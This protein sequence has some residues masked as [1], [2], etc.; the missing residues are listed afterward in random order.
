MRIFE[1]YAR[2]EPVRE[3]AGR[4][5]RNAIPSPSGSAWN[6]TVFIAGGGSGRGIIGNRIYVGELVWK[7]NRHAAHARWRAGLR[8]LRR[9]D[10]DRLVAGGE[11]A[12][13]G[14]GNA[15]DKG[16]CSNSKSYDLTEIEATVLGAIRRNL[17]VEALTAFTEGARQEWAARQKAASAERETVHR[18]LNRTVEKRSPCHRDCRQRCRDQA[19]LW[20]N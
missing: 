13:V 3:I 16:I 20:R 9:A 5:N 15:R 6:H 14:C 19:R 7:E 11:A 18:A 4:L 12:R 17:D 10:E 2:G 8:S 1:E